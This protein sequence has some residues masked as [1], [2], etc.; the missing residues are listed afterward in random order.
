MSGPVSRGQRLFVALAIL[1]GVA[2][3]LSGIIADDARVLQ[4]FPTE[5]GYFMLTI[6]RNLAIGNGFSI[7]A[8]EIP[9]NGTQPLTT[10][11]WSVAFMIAGG[12]R[13]LGVR[14]TLILE[15]IGSCV[16]A[17]MV[18]R[19]G[20]RVF[21]R[22]ANSKAISAIAAAIWF[23]SPIACRHTMNTLET[24]YNAM[25]A[26][27]VAYVFIEPDG[28][29]RQPWS[30]KKCIPV[31]VLLGIAF[32]TRNDSVFLILSACLTYVI[33][34][35]TYGMPRTVERFGRSIVFG[36]I[37]IVVASPWL[38]YNYLEFGNIM[39]VSGRAEA[40]TRI[41]RSN[42]MDLP[43]VLFE[44][45]FGAFPIPERIESM[46]VVVVVCAVVVVIT[47]L[48]AI[49]RL[50]RAATDIERSYFVFVAIYAAGLIG[51]YGEFFGAGWFLSRYLFP[52]AAF[53]ALVLSAVLMEKRERLGKLL[54]LVGVL[55]IVAS[56]V[57]NVR[58]YLNGKAHPHFQ[59][60]RYAQK[61][62]PERIWVGGV[63][64][65]TL[66]FFHDRTINLD[67]KVNIAAYH[68][69]VGGYRGRYVEAGRVEL[70]LDWDGLVR[71][72]ETPIKDANFRVLVHD[73]P[74][75]LAVLERKLRRRLGERHELHG[76]YRERIL[77]RVRASLKR[78]DVDSEGK[79]RLLL[80]RAIVFRIQMSDPPIVLAAIDDAIAPL[81]EGEA[82]RLRGR[83]ERF[84]GDMYRVSVMGK[85]AR[86]AYAKARALLEPLAHQPDVREE[87]SDIWFA[88][89]ETYRIEGN[90][91]KA[92]SAL[93]KTSALDRTPRER[94]STALALAD[95]HRDNADGTAAQRYYEQ[96]FEW[97]KSLPSTY[98]NDRDRAIVETRLG[99]LLW[100]TNVERSRKLVEAGVSRREKRAPKDG[101]PRPPVHDTLSFA[102]GILTS[103]TA[104]TET[105][106]TAR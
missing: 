64:T 66:G 78:D 22:R 71:W 36:L 84:R 94:A 79:A 74:N 95:L 100:N 18:Y 102:A 16:A 9:T 85:E 106:T 89:S 31:G 23:V 42:V 55:F 19:L 50:R 5:D 7:G 51:F 105:A 57:A 24:G 54:P 29:S 91:E 101:R 93:E 81:K 14:L 76:A 103:S 58:T 4:Q 56:T 61:N 43:P 32:W 69:L 67:G 39:P 17:F 90:F 28:P 1:V 60:I 12:E 52:L 44:Y 38:A 25:V 40:L 88:V 77:E 68:S 82:P 46:V 97:A 37:S 3:R 6:A 27:F 30:I 10:F 72:L 11:I 59:V 15:L 34:G 70:L 87:L 21:A 75:R 45:M 47:A 13:A 26:L 96:V 49:P 86:A 73:V 53:F 80:N 20:C 62:I 35:F 83:M 8:G 99:R 63:Q 2:T 48:I 33:G 104:M 98:Q 41:G 92:K 65:G